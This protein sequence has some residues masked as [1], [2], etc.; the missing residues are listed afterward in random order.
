MWARLCEISN[1][2]V[3]SQMH[4]IAKLANNIAHFAQNL[5]C[6]AA[7]SRR[8]REFALEHT[9]EIEFAKRTA[10]LNAALKLAYPEGS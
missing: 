4:D 8:A 3:I 1:A 5:E 7:C 6:L 9:F 10:S 2:G